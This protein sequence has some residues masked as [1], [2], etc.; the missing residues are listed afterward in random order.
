MIIGSLD[1]CF[2]GNII[3]SSEKIMNQKRTVDLSVLCVFV[4][5]FVYHCLLFSF[6]GFCLMPRSGLTSLE[7]KPFEE[8]YVGKGML[9]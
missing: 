7:L 6:E 2:F 5:A 4:N 9:R 3:F 1:K 8:L